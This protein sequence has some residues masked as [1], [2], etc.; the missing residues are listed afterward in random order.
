MA[1]YAFADDCE[2]GYLIAFWDGVS[3]GTKNMIENAQKYGLETFIYS[4]KREDYE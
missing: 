1:I 2:K 4:Y 3:G